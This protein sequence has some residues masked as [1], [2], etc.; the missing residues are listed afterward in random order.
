MKD[1][2][3]V[4]RLAGD[5]DRA[6]RQRRR[7]GGGGTAQVRRVRVAAVLRGVR[8]VP[9]QS[10]AKAQ[11]HRRSIIVIV[12]R[13]SE[14]MNERGIQSVWASGLV[15]RILCFFQNTAIDH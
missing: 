7:R 13:V 6:A 2:E 14:L 5:R 9:R 10:A 4:V 1:E 15:R 8:G 12:G 11:V 3:G